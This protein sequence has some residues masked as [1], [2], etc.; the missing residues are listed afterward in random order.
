[1]GDLTGEYVLICVAWPYANGPL[2]LGHVAGC[3]LPPDI[4]FRYERARGNRVLMVSGSDEHGTPITVTAETTGESPQSVVDKYHRINTEALLALG[5]A[6]EPNIDARGIEYGG[7]LFNRTSDPEHKRYV[8]DNFLSLMDAG[9][10]EKKTMQQYFEVRDEGGR[11]LPDRYIEGVCPNCDSDGA[12][13]DQCD[14]CGTTYESHEL[15]LPRSKMNPGATIEIRNTDHLFYRLDLFQAP[16]EEHSKSRDPYRKANVRAMTKQWLDMGLRPRAVTRDLEWGIS[17]P[18]DDDD[19]VGKCV[20]VWFEAVQGY[21]SCARIWA[22]RIAVDAGH[23]SGRDAWE[24]WWRISND[25]VAPRHLYFL[26]KDNIPFHTVIWPAIIMGLNHASSGKNAKDAPSLPGPG[27]LQIEHNV[28]AM[29]YL[30]LAGG[31]FSKSR[32]HAVWLPSFLER[33]D[34]DTLRY[35][36]SIN[37]PE[38]HDTDF[39]WPDFVEKV[40]NELN[41]TYGNYV[42]R[43]TSLANRLEGDNP[44]ARYESEE[45]CT[46][47]MAHLEQIHADI[48]QSLGRHRYKEALR[49]VM[50]AAQYGNQLMQHAAP[51]TH[52]KQPDDEDAK[53]SMAHLAFSWRIARFL[54]ITT[55]PFLPFSAQRL[56]EMLGQPG[57]ASEALWDSAI[58]WTVQMTWDRDKAAPLFQ[59]LDLDEILAQEKALAAGADDGMEDPGHGVKGSSRKKKGEDE[60]TEAPEGTTYIDFE[61]F[62]SVDLRTGTITTV[63]DHPNADKLIVIGIDDGSPSGRTVCAGLKEYYSKEELTGMSIVFVANLQPRE[64]RGVL[65]NGMLLAADDGEGVVRLITVDGSI[66]NGST[67]R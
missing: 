2:H 55:Q 43:I 23:S 32:K 60:M 56:W 20:Y 12:R 41:G 36:L 65:S 64:L 21:Y 35:Y 18:M 15:K 24:C 22:D 4:Q 28:P 58:D 30:M 38:S 11:F 37:M 9:L 42:N 3:Y 17:L 27:D 45:H 19:W 49:H 44:L 14:E 48:I 52:I 1:M 47:A 16:L 13:G 66:N 29:E 33:F 53:S 57:Q 54:A 25:G 7:A 5:C 10:F 34:P 40:N 46:E 67:V 50:S 59:R 8:Q 62:T 51:W 61:A 63:E 39:N 31:Q 6:W 26:G